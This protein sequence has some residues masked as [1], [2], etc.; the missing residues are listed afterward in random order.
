MA[1][2][3][4]A[5]KARGGK[6]EA[7][8]RGAKAYAAIR[9]RILSRE[10]EG[11]KAIS[12]EELAESLGISRTPVREALLL[13]Q[14]EGLIHKEPNQPFRIRIVTNREYFQSMRLRELLEGEAVRIATEK[15]DPEELARVENAMLELQRDP[16]VPAEKHWAA[17]EALH[18]MIAAA[19]G[20]DVMHKMISDLRITT[21]LFELSGLPARVRPDVEEHIH[22]IDAIKSG[23][24][25]TARDEMKRHIKSLATDVLS[26]ISRL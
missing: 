19:S 6:G 7:V 3:P 14:S 11:G 10:L 20:N 2:K 23:D 15:V 24:P 22:I 26:E 25:D 16:N 5:S 1:K 18:D 8:S 13:L 4:T 17:D 21:R 12:E 9:E